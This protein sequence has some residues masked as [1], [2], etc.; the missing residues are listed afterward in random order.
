MKLSLVSKIEIG[1]Y[2]LVLVTHTYNH[3]YLGG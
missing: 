2:D 1:L 3:S